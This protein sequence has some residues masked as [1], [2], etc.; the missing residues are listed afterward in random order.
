MAFEP[1]SLQNL[2]KSFPCPFAVQTG[3]AATQNW[4]GSA[5]FA[6]NP[7]KAVDFSTSFSFA[8][9]RMNLV[10][11]KP[12]DC[13]ADQQYWKQANTFIAHWAEGHLTIA[14]VDYLLDKLIPQYD[15]GCNC[16]SCPSKNKFRNRAKLLGH[17]CHKHLNETQLKWIQSA[18]MPKSKDNEISTTE[19]MDVVEAEVAARMAGKTITLKSVKGLKPR[20]QVEDEDSDSDGFHSDASNTSRKSASAAQPA[21]P[22]SAENPLLKNAKMVALLSTKWSMCQMKYPEEY[23]DLFPNVVDYFTLFPRATG[24]NY[25]QELQN[26][27]ALVEELIGGE[28]HDDEVHEAGLK[29]DALAINAEPSA[30]GFAYTTVIPKH[31]AK[32]NKGNKGKN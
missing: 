7:I 25:T 22:R 19:A 15:G 29:L 27:S 30:S 5:T 26:V 1:R 11:P 17:I 32:K 23:K 24:G 31:A 28:D 3:C 20:R 21:N 8:V 12:D 2:R 6:K 9:D 14:E 16:P 4:H 18:F 10:C 13:P